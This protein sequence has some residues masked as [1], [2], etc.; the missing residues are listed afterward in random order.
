[1]RHQQ[2]TLAPPVHRRGD[3]RRDRRGFGT[4]QG[5]SSSPARRRLPPPEAVRSRT[6][7]SVLTNGRIHTMD[8]RNTIARTVSIRNGRFVAVGDTLPAR[9]ANTRVVD[10]KARTAG[11]PH[12][13]PRAHRQP[14]QPSWLS[15]HSREHGVD[16]RDPGDA[17]R[18]AEGRAGG[19]V[20]YVHGRLASQPVGRAP[21]SDAYRNWTR[22]FPTA[23]CC[24]T[25]GSP[26]RARRTASARRSLMRRTPRRPFT[27]TSCR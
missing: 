11:R 24:S 2:G 26:G 7:R 19:A 12:R 22:P 10:L 17:G 9:A 15:H 13:R 23:R 4:G 6:R 8:A 20:D 27:P 3:R 18:A 16:S 21:A 1:M 14:R 25:S 5:A